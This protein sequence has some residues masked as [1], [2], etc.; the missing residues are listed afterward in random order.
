MF[1]LF[2]RVTIRSAKLGRTINKIASYSF[3][4]FLIHTHPSITGALWHGV[5]HTERFVNSPLVLI[6]LPVVALL[7]YALCCLIEQVRLWLSAPLLNSK[8]LNAWFAELDART[9]FNEE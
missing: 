9:G 6:A 5:V 8:R 1:L 4:V 7:I 3:A 2:H